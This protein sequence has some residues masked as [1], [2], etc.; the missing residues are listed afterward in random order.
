MSYIKKTWKTGK[1]IEVEKCHTGRY[2]APGQKR[3]ARVKPTREQIQKQ[4]E[5]NVQKKLRRLINANFQKDDIHLILTYK[6]ELRPNPVDAR[7]YLRA[8]L[9]KL[10]TKYRKYKKELKYIVT[11]E[12]EGKAIHHHLVI[13]DMVCGT[14]TANKLVRELWPWGRPRFTLLDDTGEYKDLAEY[15][16]KET[17]KTFR[18]EKNPNKQRY[19]CSRNLVRPEPEV[20]VVK[21]GTFREDPKPLK[22]YYIIKDSIVTGINRFTGFLYQFY[23]MRR[24][25]GK[26]WK[27]RR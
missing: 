8:F 19:S 9:G 1:V 12:W 20:E 5:R 10:R 13:N 16:I 15:L 2:G 23:S 24:L 3:Q 21:A 22:G 18:K 25:E 7:K 27:D 17:S 14:I 4:N 11:T 6:K 26:D